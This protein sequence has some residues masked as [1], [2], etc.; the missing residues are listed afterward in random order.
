MATPVAAIE[1]ISLDDAVLRAFCRRYAVRA[2]SLY[3]SVLRDDFR[4]DSDVDMLVEFQP[5]QTP[6]L[7]RFGE[8]AQD[9]EEMIGRQVD[10]K[11][12]AFFPER[13]RQ[14]VLETAQPLYAAD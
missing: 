5:G 7:F 12:L 14:S 3:G 13:I 8:M 6:S 9:L 4:L 1:R 11:T 2:L 10:L